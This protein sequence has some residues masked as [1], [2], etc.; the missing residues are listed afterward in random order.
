MTPKP[1]GWQSEKSRSSPVYFIAFFLINF[2]ED[3]FSRTFSLSTLRLFRSSL[4]FHEDL[5][6]YNLGASVQGRKHRTAFTHSPHPPSFFRES[7][8]FRLF[9]ICVGLLLSRFLSPAVV[10]Y[11]I[12]YF[13]PKKG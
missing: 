2:L 4:K 11:F 7:H 13:L 3:F 6:Y 12:F 10:Q 9:S 8:Y 5:H 1:S